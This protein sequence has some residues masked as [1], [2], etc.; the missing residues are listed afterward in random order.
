MRASLGWLA[1]AGLAST[2][3]LFAKQFARGRAMPVA[4][5]TAALLVAA[6]ASATTITANPLAGD[7]I[8]GADGKCSLREAF[9]AAN[10]DLASGGAGGECPARPGR[11]PHTH[12]LPP[13][14]FTP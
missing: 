8:N 7:T 2:P 14:R 13:G 3:A 12:S 10:T 11:G 6:P 4:V 1:R 9:I 5:A